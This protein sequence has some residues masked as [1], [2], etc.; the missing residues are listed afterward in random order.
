M[1]WRT[2]MIGWTM[3]LAVM[4]MAR[5]RVSQGDNAVGTAV[6]EFSYAKSVHSHPRRHAAEAA[7]SQRVVAPLVVLNVTSETRTN[8]AYLVTM[9]DVTQWE[10][11]HGHIPSNAVIMARSAAPTVWSS[12]PATQ[13]AS[14]GNPGRFPGFSDDVIRFLV[15]ARY[16]YGLGTETPQRGRAVVLVYR[17]PAR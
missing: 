3:A 10:D 2:F 12:H 6:V 17:P 9:G 16:A 1:R 7:H 15:E 5:P 13:A 11:A 14:E 4:L 8:P